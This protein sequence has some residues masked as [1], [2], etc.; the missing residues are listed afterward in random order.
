M[1]NAELMNEL[2]KTSAHLRRPMPMHNHGPHNGRPAPADGENRPMHGH[3]HGRRP[4]EWK[5]EACKNAENSVKCVNPETAETKENAAPECKRPD[6]QVFKAFGGI[7]ELL[8]ANA[9]M[10]QQ[11]LAD[12]L[13]IRPQSVSEALGKMEGHGLITRET[14]AEDG[15]VSLISLT[16]KGT[17]IQAFAAAEREKH[18]AFF[19]SVLTDEEKE[20][21]FTILG[22]L[23]APRACEGRCHGR[24]RHCRKP[25][26]KPA[27]E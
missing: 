16:E 26:D 8:A 15:R 1:T 21:L 23:N 14:S 19:F 3:C 10:S 25:E 7:M 9:P 4:G 6:P 17:Q 2:M 13:A 24:G 18:A 5:N 12:A 20:Q 22:K 27:E 11:Q